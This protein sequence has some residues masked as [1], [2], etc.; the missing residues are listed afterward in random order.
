MSDVVQLKALVPWFDYPS[1]QG[2]VFNHS[3]SLIAIAKTS[4]IVVFDCESG[5]Q[6][7]AIPNHG[8]TWDFA[9][10]P[11]NGLLRC[12]A[13]GVEVWDRRFQTRTVLL[14]ERKLLHRFTCARN[15][16]FIAFRQPNEVSIYSSQS[17][18]KLF[19]LKGGFDEARFTETGNSIVLGAET[20][21][22]YKSS[23]YSLKTTKR[24]A[25]LK[26]K[27][28]RP[29]A[30][31]QN[32]DSNELHLIRCVGSEFLVENLSSKAT[33]AA[34]PFPRKE[35]K[36]MDVAF[37]GGLALVSD[38]INV[39]ILLLSRS[40]ISELSAFSVENDIGQL[41]LSPALTHIGATFEFFAGIGRV[42]HL[43]V[44]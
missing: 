20:M 34:T 22:G 38:G 17:G 16:V 32:P 3:G 35:I 23:I 9:F 44:R 37:R 43:I 13:F 12:S 8:D 2:I 11:D 14:S 26:H 21:F 24:L 15:G 30:I 10:T 6:I 27:I 40:H 19:T 29:S 33:L 31:L 36:H 18:N 42:A 7:G 28:Y 5:D 4:E 25:T 39:K 41:V 1:F